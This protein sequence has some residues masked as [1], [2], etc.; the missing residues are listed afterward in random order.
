MAKGD[1]LSAHQ[2]R[3]VKRYY[4]HRDTS[5]SHKL[6]ELVSDLYLAI[7]DPRKSDKLWDAATRMLPKAGANA[8]QV[9]RVLATRNL[10]LLAK[11]VGEIVQAKPAAGGASS[12]GSPAVAGPAPSSRAPGTTSEDPR[13]HREPTTDAPEAGAAV[14][15]TPT[16]D[17]ATPVTGTSPSLEAGGAPTP[18]TLKSAL[19][20][21]RKRLK[22]TQLDEASKLGRSPLS[23][24]R[25]SVVA[26][27]PP[28]QFPRA[29]W[30]ALVAEGKLRRAGGGLYELVGA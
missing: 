14:T 28:L 5:L 21:F 23:S 29:A 15:A 11:L 12:P 4:E 1:P 27:T 7:G 3:I 22:A 30:D 9:N 25:P 24:G 26:I 8:A 6:G 20:A 2:E 16:S 18:E 13:S 19:K 10:E 17:A